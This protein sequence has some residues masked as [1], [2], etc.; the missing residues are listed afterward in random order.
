MP[1][2]SATSPVRP[3]SSTSEPRTP[4]AC[5]CPVT[6]PAGQ[7]VRGADVP[8]ED[9]SG[10]ALVQLFDHPDVACVL[11]RRDLSL[12]MVPPLFRGHAGS[13]LEDHRRAHLLTQRWGAGRSPLSRRPRGAR[14]A[15]PASPA[16]PLR[17]Q[18]S[19]RVVTGWTGQPCLV[20]R[21]ELN[22]HEPHGRCEPVR[23]H[24]QRLCW[25]CPPIPRHRCARREPRKGPTSPTQGPWP[26]GWE[27][28]PGH[29]RLNYPGQLSVSK[30]PVGTRGPPCGSGN[31]GA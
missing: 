28:G 13:W 6:S 26:S 14:R 25:S 22:R 21:Q 30:H 1:A 9:L 31:E 15:L 12:D 24:P 8:L 20:I 27:C 16:P 23:S 4:V 11:V 2:S 19:R 10:R 18:Q 17:P 5:E 29:R 3:A 7:V